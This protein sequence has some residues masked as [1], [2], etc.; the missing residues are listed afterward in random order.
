MLFYRDQAVVVDYGDFDR[1]TRTMET[2]RK[3][4]RD[5]ILTKYTPS[6]DDL[7]D[8]QRDPISRYCYLKS[9]R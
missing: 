4:M 9:N 6:R 2:A 3:Q 5:F 7:S 1:G 8:W